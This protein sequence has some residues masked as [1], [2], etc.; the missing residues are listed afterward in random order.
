[1]RSSATDPS[2]SLPTVSMWSLSRDS[3]TPVTGRF[4]AASNRGAANMIRIGYFFAG[5]GLVLLLGCG[6]RVKEEQIE[7]KPS[8]DPLSRPRAVLQQYANG[9]PMGSEVTS[10]PH[11]VEE[12]RKTDPARAD[13]LEKGLADLQKAPPGARAGKA[14][15]LLSRIA[16]SMK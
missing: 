3:E 8:N 2:A 10:F 6:Q 13:I 12:V 16:P 4:S 11:M 5:L 15:D 7:V 1:M 14:K 9:Q